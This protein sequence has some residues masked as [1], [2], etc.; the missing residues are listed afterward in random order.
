VTLHRPS[1]VDDPITLAVL[2]DLLHELASSMPLVFAVHPRTLEAARRAGLEGRLAPGQR[3][4]ICLGPQSYLDTLGLM[5]QAAV[6]LTD[7]GGI[8]EETTVLDVPCLT[9]RENTERPIT[10][11]MG[12]NRLV[13]N[14]PARIRAAFAE[15]LDGRR[16]R[17]RPIPFWDGEAGRRV[18]RELTAWLGLGPRSSRQ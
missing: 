3:P 10:L 4:L 5:A 11:A 17:S 16:P 2:L 7:S 9:L 12:T 13:G 6:V 1:N 14:D 8:Q 18:A 15:I